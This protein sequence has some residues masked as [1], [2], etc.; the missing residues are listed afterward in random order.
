M[1]PEQIARLD[2][3]LQR[4]T[5]YQREQLETLKKVAGLLEKIEARTP[6]F[7]FER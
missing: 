3:K 5:K 4:I 6:D 7:T 1:T 2:E